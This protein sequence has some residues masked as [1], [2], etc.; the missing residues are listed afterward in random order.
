M[1]STTILLVVRPTERFVVVLVHSDSPCLER[2]RRSG[3]DHVADDDD[4]RLLHALD[5]GAGDAL[6][7]VRARAEAGA[8]RLR[9]LVLAGAIRI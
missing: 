6:Q 7:G 3:A 8:A 2:D 9:T 5:L 4:D 1:P